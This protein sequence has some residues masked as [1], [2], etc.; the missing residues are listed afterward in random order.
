MVTAL[1]TK[2]GD[3]RPFH[4][5]ILLGLLWIPIVV[6]VALWIRSYHV[7][8]IFSRHSEIAYWPDGKEGPAFPAVLIHEAALGKRAIY[9]FRDEQLDS[10]AGGLKF[11]FL[12]RK[13]DLS[14]SAV[15]ANFLGELGGAV[16]P[17]V[18]VWSLKHHE[19]WGQ[20]EYA[21]YP[22]LKVP[23][24][25]PTWDVMYTSTGNWNQQHHTETL[26]AFVI[27]YWSVLV[28]VLI[29]ILGMCATIIRRSHYRL[30]NKC[31][32]CGYD[33]RATPERCPECGSPV[34]NTGMEQT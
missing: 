15:F 18:P 13:D 1:W 9:S 23:G 14:D 8:D 7:Y 20:F 6:I 31:V 19:Q 30:D 32:R 5:W 2:F 10:C 3:S 16:Y 4:F 24:D 28:V 27:P 21:E 25:N 11:R 12:S 33:L 26:V 22:Q 29:P 17:E 34:E